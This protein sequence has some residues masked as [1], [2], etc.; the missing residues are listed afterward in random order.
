[1]RDE[2]RIIVVDEDR[3]RRD[4]VAGVFGVIIF[5][6]MLIAL[7]DRGLTVAWAT[8]SAWLN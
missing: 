2:R 1:M 4:G 3:K 5:V 6:L 8:V 7:I